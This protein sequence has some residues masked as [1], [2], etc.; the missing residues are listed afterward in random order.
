[1]AQKMKRRRR[2]R[3]R[4]AKR[5]RKIRRMRVRK[6]EIGESRSTTSIDP[7]IPVHPRWRE[8]GPG[9]NKC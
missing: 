8:S 3:N 2:K 9:Q 5:K 6:R 1:M 4:M 7:H